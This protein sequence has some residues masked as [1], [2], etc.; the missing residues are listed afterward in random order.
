[1]NLKENGAQLQ[2]QARSLGFEG[3]WISML[4]VALVIAK[5]K[6]GDML[7]V[8]TEETPTG[9]AI[10]QSFFAWDEKQQRFAFREYHASLQKIVEIPDISAA[11]IE[12]KKL[13]EEMNNVDWSRNTEDWENDIEGMTLRRSKMLSV[14]EA[15]FEKL[16]KLSESGADGRKAADLLTAKYFLHT[17]QE[18]LAHPELK[19]QYFSSRLFH[20]NEEAGMTK[21]E[22]F[23]ILCGRTVRKRF[24]DINGDSCCQ[25]FQMREPDGIVPPVEYF[26]RDQVRLDDFHLSEDLLRLPL[27]LPGRKAFDN[28]CESLYAGNI[29]TVPMF[30]HG[31]REDLCLVAKPVKKGVE[32]SRPDGSLVTPEEL[33][34]RPLKK[35][36]AKATKKKGRKNGL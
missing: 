13:D 36:E 32:I 11:G 7:F 22:A 33:L 19:K 23:N 24:K 20:L 14:A 31:K 12:V 26:F 34:D 27:A 8:E 25:W 18:R 29:E 10:Y 6:G 4:P 30:H 28:L 35:E 9:K 17:P 2:E 15:I 21:R 16:E 1:M 5:A 3:G